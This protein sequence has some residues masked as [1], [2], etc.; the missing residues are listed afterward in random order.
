MFELV[1]AM[2]LV[3]LFNY[4]GQNIGLPKILQA[5]PEI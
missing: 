2:V 4:V 1:L 5:R 3:R